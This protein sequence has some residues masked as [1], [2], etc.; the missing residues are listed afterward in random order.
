MA[1]NKELKMRVVD[2]EGLQRRLSAMGAQVSET[3]HVQCAYFLQP[4]GQ[5]L[6]LSTDQHGSTLTHL[7]ASNGG[8]D[9]LRTEAV[10]DPAARTEELDATFGRKSTLTKNETL[11][12]L[13]GRDY[14][15]LLVQIPQVGDFA[16]ILHPHPTVEMAADLGLSEAEVISVPFDEI[17]ALG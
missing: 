11:H 4:A 14:T 5:V 15:V 2:L 1:A 6:K 10:A 8:F 16:V 3:L 7:Q 17:P 12:T 9:L 13:P